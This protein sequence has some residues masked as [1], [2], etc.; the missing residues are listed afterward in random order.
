MKNINKK[1][2]YKSVKKGV[3]GATKHFI[4]LK[5]KNARAGTHRGTN[6]SDPFTHWPI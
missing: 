3:A 5:L 6:T 2:V 4:D 1:A